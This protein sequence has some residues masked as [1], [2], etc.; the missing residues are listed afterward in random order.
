M[1]WQKAPAVCANNALDHLCCLVAVIEY[2]QQAEDLTGSHAVRVY[3][4]A[5]KTGCHAVRVSMHAH[6]PF[7]NPIFSGFVP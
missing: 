5:H 3:T 7:R 2:L 4:Q 6:T 1:R